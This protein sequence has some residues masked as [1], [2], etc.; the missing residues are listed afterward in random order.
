MIVGIGIDVVDIGR[1]ERSIART[2]SLVERLFAE[3][4]RNRPARSLHLSRPSKD[5]TRSS[6]PPVKL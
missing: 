1:F 5:E 6:I 2:P 3:S 4:E